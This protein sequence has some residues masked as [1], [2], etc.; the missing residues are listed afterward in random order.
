[1]RITGRI[2]Y[3]ISIQCGNDACSLHFITNFYKSILWNECDDY[4]QFHY[5]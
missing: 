1:M 5:Q 4:F 2:P 3:S